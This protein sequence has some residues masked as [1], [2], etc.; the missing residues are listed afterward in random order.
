[1]QLVHHVPVPNIIAS[2]SPMSQMQTVS[3]LIPE[4]AVGASSSGHV[5][6]PSAAVVS[7]SSPLSPN[8]L[9]VSV[10]SPPPTPPVAPVFASSAGIPQTPSVD[11][12]SSAASLVVSQSADSFR[13]I[14]DFLRNPG[15]PL[16]VLR[17]L[18]TSAFRE[19]LVKIDDL[20]NRHQHVL[21]NMDSMA[22]HLADPLFQKS[23]A[24]S[25]A[26]PDSSL[27]RTLTRDALDVFPPD[28]T[29]GQFKQLLAEYLQPSA[30][31]LAEVMRYFPFINPDK[32]AKGTRQLYS[33]F[34]RVIKGIL[35]YCR[36]V[37]LPGGCMPQP[38]SLTTSAAGAIFLRSVCHRAVIPFLKNCFGAIFRLRTCRYSTL[39]LHSEPLVS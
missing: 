22:F 14:S 9:F 32:Y 2:L 26:G 33:Q 11:M 18:G 37:R 4:P 5:A 23:G 15:E 17:G 29:W 27:C 21:R 19:F 3:A 28:F 12:T 30:P 31:T 39:Q 24:A 35:K 6:P 13:A 36:S 1:V 34:Q 16:P 20:A 8:T 38:M 25:R 7:P 10:S